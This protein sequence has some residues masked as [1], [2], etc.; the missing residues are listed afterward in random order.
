MSPAA[1]LWGV[2]PDLPRRTPPGH[3]PYEEGLSLYFANISRSDLVIDSHVQNEE[4][5]WA[6]SGANP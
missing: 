2:T 6:C 3:R 4:N 5:G 1:Y